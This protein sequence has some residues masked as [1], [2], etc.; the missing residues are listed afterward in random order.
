VSSEFE[1][2]GRN[3][4]YASKCK[5]TVLQIIVAVY[6]VSA[7]LYVPETEGTRSVL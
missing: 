1:Q 4:I 6:V 5:E 7:E 3:F 2:L